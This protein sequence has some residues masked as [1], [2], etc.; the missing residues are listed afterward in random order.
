MTDVDL[1]APEHIADPYPTYERLRAEGP[2]VAL[3]GDRF[4]ATDHATVTTILRNHDLF[5]SEATG[6]DRD[7][8][9]PGRGEKALAF[10]SD[11]PFR[12]VIRSDPPDHTVLRRLV[13]E[14]FTPRAVAALEP[15]IRRIAEGCIDDLL[16][17]GTEA[18]FVR[19]VAVPLPVT[20]IA[21]MLD[22]PI[23]RRDDFKRWSD[24]LALS[25]GSTT[26]LD[27]GTAG[28]MYSF[29]DELVRARSEHPGDDLMSRLIRGAGDELTAVE[30]V[31]F[32]QLLLVAGNETTTNLLGN[33]L[34]ALFENPG[35]AHEVRNE[36]SSVPALFEEALRFDSPVQGT[37]R[38]V[39]RDTVLCNTELSTDSRVLVLLASANRD[40][41]AFPDPD[42][43]H[44]ARN[45]TDH[46]AFGSG[47][48]FCLGAGL[49]RLEARIVSDVARFRIRSLTPN[50]KSRRSGS[51]LVRGFSSIPVA[52]VA[53]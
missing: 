24:N 53:A 26:E 44:P 3:G 28:E 29:F 11:E 22:I 48:H 27:P 12:V 14:P 23:G 43:F 18:D 45:P 50:G 34:N 36:P 7:F 33:C 21:E 47:I 39:T 4:L 41:G 38:R 6:N 35:S 2:V 30:V 10:G 49:T 1:L 51:S 17:H 19:D 40:P 5:S 13:R 31:V 8:F 15:K 37:L 32:C 9:R 16:A 42:T 46:V 20:V 25:V 52:A